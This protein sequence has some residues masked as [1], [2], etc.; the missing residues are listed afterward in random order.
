M[1]EK[2]TKRIHDFFSGHLTSATSW[3]MGI[4]LILL[5]M[6]A[7]C[8]LFPILFKAG[9]LIVDLIL[10][11][12][13]AIFYACFVSQMEDDDPARKKCKTRLMLGIVLVVAFA[14]S[15]FG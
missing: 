13:L 8:T 4:D 7:L 1:G 15:A 9:L 3:L 5:L 11:G 14:L 12:T 10:A 6:F 2:I